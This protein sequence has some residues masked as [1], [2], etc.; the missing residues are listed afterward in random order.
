MMPLPPDRAG[1]IRRG[2]RAFGLEILRPACGLDLPIAL[3]GLGRID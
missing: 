1:S 3:R 2:F